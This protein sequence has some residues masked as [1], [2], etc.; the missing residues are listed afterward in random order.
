MPYKFLTTIMPLC[1]SL[2]AC[3]AHADQSISNSLSSDQTLSRTLSL[4]ILAHGPCLIADARVERLA[5]PSLVVALAPTL[6]DISLNAVQTGIQKAAEAKE[7]RLQARTNI[8][9][10]SRPIDCIWFASGDF[11]VDTASV[12]ISK[13]HLGFSNDLLISRRNS[14]S[15]DNAALEAALKVELESLNSLLTDH[16]L[17]F[18]APPRFFFEARINTADDGSAI[19]IRPTYIFYPEIINTARFW[20]PTGARDILMLFSFHEAASYGSTVT[21]TVAALQF[22]GLSTDPF[23]FRFNHY[24]EE[25]EAPTSRNIDVQRVETPYVPNVLRSTAPLVLEVTIVE[26]RDASALLTR[27]AEFIATEGPSLKEPA[28]QLV[29]KQRRAEAERT[30]RQNA[31]SERAEMVKV[32]SDAVS[33]HSAFLASSRPPDKAAELYELMLRANEAARL[34]ADVAAPFSSAEITGVLDDAIKR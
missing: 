26:T 29:D 10:G 3:F 2:S 12:D 13:N 32:V 33:A 17:P 20:E 15:D 28:L 8:N 31:I 16:G 9:T 4:N 6:F 7:T 27:F 21:T 18:A 5:I 30:A 34:L 14:S 1:L 24:K 25:S 11:F 22:L 19:S 23:G